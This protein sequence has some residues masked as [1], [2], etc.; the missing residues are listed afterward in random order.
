MQ[1]SRPSNLVLILILGSLTTVSPFS[2]DMYLPAFSQIADALGT[3]AAEVSLSLASYFIGVAVGQ[4]FYGPLLDR[5]GRKRPVYGG[6]SLYIL[7]SIGCLLAQ[8][9]ESLILWRF[10]Q[11]LGGCVAAVASMAMVRD[12]FPVQESA[13][14]FSLM[15]LIL[16][17]S[18]L[19]A[20]T[21]G[22]FVTTWLGWQWVFIT[23][24]V[25]VATILIVAATLLPESHAPDPTVS[26]RPLPILKSFLEVLRVPQFHTYALAGSFSFSGLLVYIAGSPIIFMDVF[27]MSAQA[28]G[29]VFA[30]LSVGFIGGNQLNMLL[31]RRF[32]GAQIFRYAL[33]CQ[34]VIV[35]G[36]LIGTLLGLYGLIATVLFFFGYLACLGLTFPNASAIALGPFT[37]NG[38]TAAALIGFLQVGIGSLASAG[39][40]LFNAKDSKAVVIILT[41]TV[42]TGLAILLLGKHRLTAAAVSAA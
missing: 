37:R 31:L 9:V 8:S 25:I 42:L 35:V 13:K 16:G 33:I 30:I 20:P 32:S 4:I 40:G 28:Y 34:A 2:I 38:G 1:S 15:M 19:L 36:F 7:A 17:V 12:L 6:L 24:A 39:V 21:L 14:V 22:G 41:G 26:L 11:G 10:A 18:P 23:L 29:V 27:G 5:Y 3:T